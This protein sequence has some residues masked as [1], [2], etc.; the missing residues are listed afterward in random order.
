MLHPVLLET[1]FT[2]KKKLEKPTITL[3][4]LTRSEA[5]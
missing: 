1:T 2:F 5:A 3:W 4:S